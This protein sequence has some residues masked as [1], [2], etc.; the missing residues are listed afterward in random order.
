MLGQ[1]YNVHSYQFLFDYFQFTLIHLPVFYAVLF[2]TALNFTFTTRN[3]HNWALF[4]LW[5]SL[6]DPSG[7][8]SLILSRSILD[9]YQLGRFIIQCHN[10][11]LFIL[12]TGSSRQE[13][14]CGLLFPSPMYYILSEISTMTS[15]PWWG[16]AL[17]GMAHNFIELDKA[18]IH[19]IIL[20][21]FLWLCFLFCLPSDG[22]G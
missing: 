14:R 18:V 1:G 5:L 16:E 8:I 6:F 21:T 9:T 17:H 13:C 12:F 10:F 11:C 19:V 20:V 2:F 22:W 7:A 15:V 4:L 3:T